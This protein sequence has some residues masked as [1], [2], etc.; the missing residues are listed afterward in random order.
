MKAIIFFL[1]VSLIAAPLAS[2]S[3]VSID[4]ARSDGSKVKV[5][6]RYQF[7]NGIDV[8]YNAETKTFEVHAGSATSGGESAVWSAAMLQVIDKYAPSP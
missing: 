7:E 3:A 5:R 6:S 4:V 1:L 8:L 2:C